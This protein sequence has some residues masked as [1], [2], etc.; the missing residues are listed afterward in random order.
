MA[1]E[2]FGKKMDV[3]PPVR[4]VNDYED[5][6]TV[7]YRYRSTHADDLDLMSQRQ[8]LRGQKLEQVPPVVIVYHV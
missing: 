3:L 6:I 7:T 5:R 8:E 2:P 4:R 1:A